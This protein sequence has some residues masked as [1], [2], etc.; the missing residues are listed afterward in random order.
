[1]DRKKVYKN[2]DGQ[3]IFRAN[4]AFN[5]KV[6]PTYI[7]SDYTLDV[8]ETTHLSETG[9][10]TIFAIDSK[11]NST[12][13]SFSARWDQ[14]AEA[15]DIDILNVDTNVGD[16]FKAEKDGYSGHHSL[17]IPGDIRMYDVSVKIPQK[18]IFRANVSFNI[19]KEHAPGLFA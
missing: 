12:L 6:E 3:N 15:L 4:R 14:N 19:N 8:A 5:L 9:L 2:S 18:E 16:L 1:M 7:D 10:L 11:E 13:P 17:R